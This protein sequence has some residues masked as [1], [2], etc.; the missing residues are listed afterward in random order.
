MKD[1]F[2][3]TFLLLSAL[4]LA[5]APQAFSFGWP[6]KNLDPSKSA[7]TFSQNRKGSYCQSL[8]FTN[9][10]GARAADKGKV[11]AVLTE[12]QGDGD[13]FESPLGN[14]LV[15]SH[16]DGL[17]SVYGNL[18]AQTA[19]ALSRKTM[20]EDEEDLGQ[21]AASAWSESLEGGELEFQISD[22]ESKSFINPM[23]L[24]PRTLKPP[25]I[26]LEGITIE[27]QF[28]RLYNLS[29]LRSVPA[30]VYKIY[31]K[32]QEN[33][34][35]YKS[36]VYVNGSELEKITK[37]TIKGQNGRLALAGQSL[38]VSGEFFP[39][40]SLE[41]LGHIL[42]PHGSNTVTVTATNIFESSVSA[43]FTVA[44]Y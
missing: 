11:I 16:N 7:F 33:I 2:S 19:Q 5:A 27:N 29:S 18:S 28:G 40:D 1:T 13:W 35:V 41:L 38:Y 23:I 22:C 17:L 34:P 42:L 4:L 37:E 20:V 30:G 32:R 9:A 44:G 31:K 36:E 25:R 15:I 26:V 6:V 3:K 43:N 24:M 12:R 10:Q 21:T 39:D 8:L 14:A